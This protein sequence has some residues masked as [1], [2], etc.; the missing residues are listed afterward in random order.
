MCAAT[1]GTLWR[2]DTF[3][4]AWRKLASDKAGVGWGIRASCSAHCR[5]RLAVRLDS[6]RSLLDSPKGLSR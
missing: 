6:D 3:T 1:D 4:S 5:P 2:P